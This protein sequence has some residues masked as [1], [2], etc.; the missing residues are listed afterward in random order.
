[1]SE[2]HGNNY[3]VS[4]AL[5]TYNGAKYLPD[6]LESLCRQTLQ[7]AEILVFDDGSSDETLSVLDQY[8]HRLPIIVHVNEQS[9]GVVKNFKGA[10]AACKNDY[11]ALCDQDDVWFPDK[12][13]L[14]MDKLLEIDGLLPAMVFTD[15]TVVDENLC[16]TADSYWQHRKLKPAKE[17]F[18]S[19][20]WGNFVTG[21]TM[22]INKPMTIEVAK[23]PDTVLMHDFWIAYVAYGIGRWAYVDQ[24][25]AFYRQHTSNVTNND[26]VTWRSRQK[27]LIEFLRSADLYLQPQ[28]NQAILFNDLYSK[29]LPSGNKNA[30]TK[31]L[32]VR[33]HSPLCRK[34][35]AFLVKFLH[36]HS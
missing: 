18:A 19:L 2:P 12:L 8:S 7:P 21:F 27:R 16:I 32:A 1:M 3:K 34:W 36:I 35:S 24:P 14:S 22:I 10:I 17:T 4:V 13:A 30:L 23:M 15:L 5:A 11:I 9:I 20:L 31:F 26:A 6:L 33:E 25:T 28:L 29:R